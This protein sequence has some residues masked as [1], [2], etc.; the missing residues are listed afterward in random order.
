MLVSW[1][2]SWSWL[3]LFVWYFALCDCALGVQF[4]CRGRGSGGMM[5]VACDQSRSHHPESSLCSHHYIQLAPANPLKYSYD[6]K[7]GVAE[8]D[9]SSK[10]Q[11]RHR[12]RPATIPLLSHSE[13]G[14]RIEQSS[15]FYPPCAPKQCATLRSLCLGRHRR[16]CAS[17][18]APTQI[19]K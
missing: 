9:A 16:L 19:K 13:A 12:Q 7:S 17:T 6:V 3:G 18:A 1:S 2:W 15:Q 10:H 5:T 4:D 8:V 14:G 11:L